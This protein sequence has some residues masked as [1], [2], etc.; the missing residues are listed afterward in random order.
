M[1]YYYFVNPATSILAVLLVIFSSILPIVSFLSKAIILGVVFFTVWLIFAIG[2]LYNCFGKKIKIDKNGI[3]YLSLFKQI[4]LS[5]KEIEEIGIA[6][7]YVGF[8]GGAPFIYFSVKHG[9]GNYV[10]PNMISNELL[11][12]R[13]RKSAMKN[14]AKYWNKQ[15][16]GVYEN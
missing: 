7:Y 15:I 14:I 13:Y 12:M 6:N 11:M 8:R 16:Y 1:K 4:N 2:I 10:N 9:I 3:R 5:W